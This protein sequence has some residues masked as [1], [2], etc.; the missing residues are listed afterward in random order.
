M[1]LTRRWRQLIVVALGLC[2]SA[3]SLPSQT[4]PPSVGTGFGVDTSITDVRK[5]VA[6]VRAY[7]TEPDST[8][9][10]R[11]LWSTASDFDRRV[12]DATADQVNQGFPATVIGVISVPPGDSLYVVKILYARGDTVEGIAPLALQRLYAVREPNSLYGFKLSAPMPR[13]TRDWERRTKGPITYIYAPG[14]HPNQARIDSAARFIDSVAKLFNV[15]TPDHFDVVIGSSMDEVERAIGLDFFVEPSGPGQRTGGRNIGSILLMGNPT[16]GEMY[17]HEF[18]HA[19]LGPH[20][21]AGSQILSEGVATW[22]GGSLGRS[23]PEVYAAVRQYQLADPSFSFSGFFRLGINDT[24]PKFA[25]DV[26]YGTGALIANAVYE[27]HGIAGVRR[28]YLTAG[29]RETVLREIARALDLDPD[30]PAAFDRWWRAEATRVG[31][32]R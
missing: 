9:H 32:S 3:A 4:A 23:A 20:L 13:V 27:R 16:I 12:G 31:G 1:P 22:L 18:V 21:R 2:A 29:S 10:T 19:V 6:L 28:L 8:A 17:L 26:L 15:P 7:L 5:V 24:D 11:G 25:S 14:E 30:D